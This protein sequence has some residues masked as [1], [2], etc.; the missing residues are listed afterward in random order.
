MRLNSIANSTPDIGLQFWLEAGGL[1]F[2]IL[3][4]IL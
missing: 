4:I 1:V 2:I 3:M